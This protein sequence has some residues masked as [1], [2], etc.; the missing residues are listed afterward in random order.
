[1]VSKTLTITEEVYHILK[2]IKRENESFSNLLR[3][4]AMEVNGQKLDAFFGKWEMND[5]EYKDIQDQINS[6]KIQYNADKVKFN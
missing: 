2:E 6:Q 4:L 3:R 1:M 5:Q